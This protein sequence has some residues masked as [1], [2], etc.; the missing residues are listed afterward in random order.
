VLTATLETFAESGYDGVSIGKVARRS[1]VHE[2]SIYRRWG[3]RDRLILEAMVERSAALLRVP[4]TGSVRE[5]LI[6]LGRQMVD[7][8]T[9]PPGEA[10]MRTL[11]S[12][13]DDVEAS[14]VRNRFWA[15]RLSECQVLVERAKGRG[16]IAPETDSRW[17]LELFIAPIHFRLL[18][19]RESVDLFDL[20]QLADAA[21]AGSAALG[22]H[23]A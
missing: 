9:S 22:G 13:A 16:E 17:L 1:G 2:T 12:N 7:Y 6:G 19:T 14:A 10:L 15:A 20:E 8:G 11:A 23:G 21:L 5:D 4:D 18:M 3:T